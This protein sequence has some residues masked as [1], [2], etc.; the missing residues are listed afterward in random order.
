MI[1]V[2]FAVAVALS[3]LRGDI[4]NK[5][6][7]VRWHNRGMRQSVKRLVELDEVTARIGE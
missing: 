5:L 2:W 3:G 7:P 1:F 6:T 4:G